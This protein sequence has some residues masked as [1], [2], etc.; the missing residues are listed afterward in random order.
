[1]F[2]RFVIF[3]GKSFTLT[4]TVSTN[5]PMITTYSKAIKVTVDGPR[6]PRSKTSKYINRVTDE[7]KW[8]SLA[9]GTKTRPVK[10]I[11]NVRPLLKSVRYCVSANI[12]RGP[13]T[14]YARDEL[15]VVVDISLSTVEINFETHILSNSPKL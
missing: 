4:I 6:E 9:H 15:A 1:M 3:A 8:F 12:N 11:S 10:G 5:P 2:G 7:F 14:D 13:K